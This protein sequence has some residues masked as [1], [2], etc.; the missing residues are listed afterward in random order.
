MKRWHDQI[1]ALKAIPKGW[2]TVKMLAAQEKLSSAGAQKRIEEAFRHKILVRKSW[3]NPTGTGG[4]VWIYQER[5]NGHR[6]KA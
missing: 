1:T 2:F 6:A 3:P 4:P 5:K